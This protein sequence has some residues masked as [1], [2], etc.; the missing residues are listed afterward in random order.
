[1]V[2]LHCNLDEKTKHLI[3]AERLSMMKPDAVLVNAA[4]GPVID[5]AALVS[6]LQANPEFRRAP[7]VPPCTV[8][9]SRSGV[10]EVPLLT[11]GLRCI[12]CAVGRSTTACSTH[13]D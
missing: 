12:A 8:A 1:M 9:G 2:S 10:A 6:H 11:T 3:N 4:R 13:G 7:R 5:E